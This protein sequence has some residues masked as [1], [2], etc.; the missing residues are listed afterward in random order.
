MDKVYV[1]LSVSRS[2][3]LSSSYDVQ[4]REIIERIEK[5]NCLIELPFISET[6]NM[7]DLTLYIKSELNSIQRNINDSAVQVLS[8]S[9]YQQIDKQTQIF[10]ILRLILNQSYLSQQS[11]QI[12]LTNISIDEILNA[13]I[14]HCEQKFGRKICSFIFN[15]ISS[16]QSA[17]AE[18]E[19]LDILSCNNE[20]FLEYYQ[21]DLPKHLRFPP[22]L[23]IAVKYILG[24][25]L[26]ER[27][28]DLK[29]VLCWS[30]SFIRRHMKQRY[31][32]KV[33][34][35]RIAHRDIANYFLEAFIESKPL[36]DMNRNLQIR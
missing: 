30:H 14:D 10:Y 4:I 35:I 25:L 27:Y 9:I 15:Y 33:E 17:I 23:W 22:S 13:Y 34:D 32:K 19:L 1:I 29:V 16:S 24:P 28:F 21:K 12:N 3:H 5:E 36:V 31:L 7:Q 2:V 20:F 6:I 18:I 26:S 11:K 8:K